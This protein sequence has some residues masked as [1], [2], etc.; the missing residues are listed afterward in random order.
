MNRYY[1]S[2]KMK[3]IFTEQIKSLK[4]LKQSILN[5]GSIQNK[6]CDNIHKMVSGKRHDTFQTFVTWA[7]GL[8]FL[9]I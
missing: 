5:A 4:L 9:V 2:K 6:V 8:D 1:A 3:T 7:F